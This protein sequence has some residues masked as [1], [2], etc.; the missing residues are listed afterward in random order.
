M[1]LLKQIEFDKIFDERNI[2]VLLRYVIHVP[3]FRMVNLLYC[4]DQFSNIT[5]IDALY[6]LEVS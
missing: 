5:F 4:G 1:T 2:H 3:S 6:F